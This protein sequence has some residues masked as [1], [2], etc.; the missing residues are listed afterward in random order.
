MQSVKRRKRKVSM[1]VI[2]LFAFFL[3]MGMVPL[4]R[5]G[6]APEQTGG[7]DFCG[8]RIEILIWVP[9]ARVG[10]GFVSC[11]VFNEFMEEDEQGN[12]QNAKKLMA[13]RRL[14]R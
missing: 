1:R 4:P 2:S 5:E 3:L 8:K 12:A 10:P 7:V 13:H 6:L 9:D 11:D 14:I